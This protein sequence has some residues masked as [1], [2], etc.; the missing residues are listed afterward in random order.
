MGG[1][2]D[3]LG[4]DFMSLVRLMKISTNVCSTIVGFGSAA[5]VALCLDVSP[6][7]SAEFI[8][9]MSNGAAVRVCRNRQSES[10]IRRYNLANG[11]LLNLI[12]IFF[13]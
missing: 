5:Q 1:N 9:G 3:D 11:K 4:L 8:I 12:N 10:Q 7:K 13:E 2:A 6:S